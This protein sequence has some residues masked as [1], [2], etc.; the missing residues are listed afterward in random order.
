MTATMLINLDW[1]LAWE[2]FDVEVI[3]YG[4]SV[5]AED[6]A[7]VD[8]VVALSVI[9]YASVDGDPT[10]YDEEWLAEEIASLADYVEQGGFLVLTHS[11]NYVF[12]GRVVDVNEDWEDVNVLA[13]RFGIRFAGEPFRTIRAR[14]TGAHPI[15]GDLFD[16][17][18]MPDNG[19]PLSL[20]G[21]EALA[22]AEGEV[23]I[24]LV[25]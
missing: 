15:T 11:A 19:L 16:L 10:L 9:E 2:G 23:A 5:T 6:L 7:E 20:T 14:V 17:V 24:G 25:G 12:R 18:M 4:Q 1:A 3:P 13:A 21:G 22:E 8:L